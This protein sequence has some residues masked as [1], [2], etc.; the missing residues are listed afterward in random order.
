[1]FSRPNGDI[2]K[3]LSRLNKLPTATAIDRLQQALDIKERLYDLTEREQFNNAI[4]EFSYFAKKV[5]PQLKIMK[6]AIKNF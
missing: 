3:N 1:M 4:L 5:V 6:K 2:E